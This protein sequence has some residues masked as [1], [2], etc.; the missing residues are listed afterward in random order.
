MRYYLPPMLLD[1]LLAYAHFVA[2]FA[3][4]FFLLLE[5]IRC[6]EPVAQSRA[7][8]LFRVDLAYFISA[9]AVL[10][11]GLLRAFFGAKGAA[12]YFTNAA[13]HAKLGVFVLIAT[14]SI[15]VTLTYM[16]WNKL[17]RTGD[18]VVPAAEVRR[19]RVY[20]WIELALLATLPALAVIMARG[21]GS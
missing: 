20:L 9:M 4:G 13:F 3:L 1:A 10:V 19:V 5:W 8:V 15:P 7:R 17:L 21:L 6:R 11:T 2:I 12:F 16:R 14:L 18:G